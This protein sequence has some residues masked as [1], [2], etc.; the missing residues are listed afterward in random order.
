[1]ARLLIVED[2]ADLSG[3]LAE[4]LEPRGYALDFAYDG[5]SAVALAGSAEFDLIVLD[6]GLPRLDGVQVAERLRV[7]SN[8]AL[9]LMLTARDGLDDKAAAY[10]AG[11]DDY[12][13]KPFALAELEM[14]IKALLRR[15]R[16]PA[17]VLR[18]A[19]LEYDTGTHQVRRSGRELALNRSQLQVLALLMRESPRL[20]SKA[21]LAE[22]LWGDEPGSYDTLRS[23]V[24]ELRQIVDRPFAA[25]TPLI[26][27]LHSQGY[28]L[29]EPADDD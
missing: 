12:L 29:R 3:N 10:A 27:T 5:S 8:R 4:Y 15:G 16:A 28:A 2:D 22:H 14:R 1:M 24:H 17:G 18:V 20:V 19:D 13:T 7:A 23:Y 6:I 9:L 25:A 11:A 21:R 26:H